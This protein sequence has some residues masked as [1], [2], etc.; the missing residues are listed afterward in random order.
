MKFIH[1]A[2]IHLDS[3]L[4]GLQFYEGRPSCQSGNWPRNMTYLSE[5]IEAVRAAG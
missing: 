3:P 2:D 1:A 5:R 4:V